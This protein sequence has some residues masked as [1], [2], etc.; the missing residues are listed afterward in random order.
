MR[1]LKQQA[2]PSSQRPQ[3]PL[4]GSL[5]LA[6]FHLPEDLRLLFAE[7]VLQLLSVFLVDVKPIWQPVFPCVL[8]HAM[9]VA[10]LEPA[11]RVQ[12]RLLRGCQLWLVLLARQ[13]CNFRTLDGGAGNT[14]AR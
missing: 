10:L 8:Q 9:L 3:A 14:T 13:L 4:C 1:V 12:E 6:F 7:K 5:V 2:N 11:L